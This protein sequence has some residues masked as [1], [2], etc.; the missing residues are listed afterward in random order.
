LKCFPQDYEYNCFDID[1]K[2]P[3]NPRVALS[4]EVDGLKPTAV[5]D[6]PMEP[7]LFVVSRNAEVKEIVSPVVQSL[8]LLL[9]IVR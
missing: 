8:L 6:T 9:F 3:L 2:D 7:R 1:L 4:G 5:T